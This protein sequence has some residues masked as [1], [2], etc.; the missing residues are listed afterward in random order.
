MAAA[1]RRGPLSLD[2]E[3]ARC[4]GRKGGRHSALARHLGGNGGGLRQALGKAQGAP[5]AGH[6]IGSR[7]PQALVGRLLAPGRAPVKIRAA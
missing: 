7:S 4:A 3:R 2:H 6:G 1:R 5:D